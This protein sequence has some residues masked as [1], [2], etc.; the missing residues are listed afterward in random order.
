MGEQHWRTTAQHRCQLGWHRLSLTPGALLSP[1]NLHGSSIVSRQFDL[2]NTWTGPA[3]FLSLSTSLCS[4][5][6]RHFRQSCHQRALS[7]HTPPCSTGAFTSF[8]NYFPFAFLLA[9]LKSPQSCY[10][11]LL[12]RIFRHLPKVCPIR[13][14]IPP[15]TT[16]VNILGNCNIQVEGISNALV[17]WPLRK[18]HLRQPSGPHSSTP[19]C[20]S[21]C[22]SLLHLDYCE[23]ANLIITLSLQSPNCSIVIIT[24]LYPPLG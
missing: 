13:E 4:K 20:F 23:A 8:Q 7:L 10:C 14:D 3:S 2:C 18:L 16:P 17:S 19:P 6:S 21:A 5:I 15:F 22:F 1:S 12:T 24:S 11:Y 9:I